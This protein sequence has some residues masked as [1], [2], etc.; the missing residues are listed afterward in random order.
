MDG[1]IF[2]LPIMGSGAQKSL[3]FRCAVALR[4][5]YCHARIEAFLFFVL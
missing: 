2:L 3:E 1:G 5:K 4:D